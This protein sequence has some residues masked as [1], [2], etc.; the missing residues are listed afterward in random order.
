MLGDTVE[1]A[2]LEDTVEHPVPGTEA[3]GHGEEDL[4]SVTSILASGEISRHFEQADEQQDDRL[5]AT[6]EL[7]RLDETAEGRLG[8]VDFSLGDEAAT[9]SEVGTKR[10]LALAYIDMGAPEGAR[11]ILGEVLQEGTQGEK[12]EADRLVASLP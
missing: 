9:M 7:P 10:D 12:Q 8:A 4:L 6:G 5:D 1:S 3:P 2:A 11:S